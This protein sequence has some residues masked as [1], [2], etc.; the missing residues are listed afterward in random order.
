MDNN[1]DDTDQDVDIDIILME[2][3]L[4]KYWINFRQ[5]VLLRMN[6]QLITLK[7]SQIIKII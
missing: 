7:K 1:E 5:H 4:P 6:Q 2:R 3:N